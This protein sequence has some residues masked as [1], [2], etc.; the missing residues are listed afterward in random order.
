MLRVYNIYIYKKGKTH[1][2][3]PIFLLFF[4]F[5]FYNFILRHYI[6]VFLFSYRFRLSQSQNHRSGFFSIIDICTVLDFPQLHIDSSVVALSPF[7]SIFFS[8]IS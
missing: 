3:V 5:R 6:F 1:F 8:Q 2:E 7:S 4:I